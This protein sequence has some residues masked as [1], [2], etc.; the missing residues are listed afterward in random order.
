MTLKEKQ[1][2]MNALVA[3]RDELEDQLAAIG[4][5]ER[6]M[7]SSGYG[8]DEMKPIHD[9]DERLVWKWAEVCSEINDLERVFTPEDSDINNY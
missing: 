7:E 8:L 4:K 6:L 9:M 5:V 3:T 1:A 2:K